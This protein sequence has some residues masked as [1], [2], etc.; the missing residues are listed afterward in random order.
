MG[1]SLISYRTSSKS[2]LA[3]FLRILTQGGRWSTILSG[4]FLKDFFLIFDPEKPERNGR[5]WSNLT[6]AGTSFFTSNLG[7][8]S[9]AS[10]WPTSSLT[11]PA[12]P[13]IESE[14]IFV[15]S[16]RPIS[17][18]NDDLILPWGKT[19]G[20][21]VFFSDS[22][23]KNGLGVGPYESFMIGVSKKRRYLRSKPLLVIDGVITSTSGVI[24]LLVLTTLTRK[25]L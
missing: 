13:F 1:W 18:V 21:H 24:T 6:T 14:G 5:K 2:L 22:F 7:E 15:T 10:N 17:T 20:R 4:G 23:S 19:K 11:N 25:A 3:K 8:I 12:K 16:K 9:R